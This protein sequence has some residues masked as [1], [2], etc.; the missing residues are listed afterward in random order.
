[1]GFVPEFVVVSYPCLFRNINA[2]VSGFEPEKAVLET[3][4][5][6]FHHTPS[7]MAGEETPILPLNYGPKMFLISYY[8]IHSVPHCIPQ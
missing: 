5:I 6:P 3:A 7:T 4:V 1:M 2:G 8:T